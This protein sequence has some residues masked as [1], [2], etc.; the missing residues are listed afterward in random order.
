MMC[1]LCL[2]SLPRMEGE[3]VKTLY[4]TLAYGAIVAMLFCGRTAYA[5]KVPP[6]EKLLK[7]LEH[8]MLMAYVLLDHSAL[9]AIYADEYTNTSYDG[10]VFTKREV[11]DLVKNASLRL[12]S[13]PISDSKVKLLGNVAVITGVR[14]YWR[15]GKVLGVVRYTEVW[16]NRN[17]RW[18]CLSGQLTSVQE[19]K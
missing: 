8:Q 10:T 14:K 7:N 16:I 15:A 9:S 12:D 11:V 3:F 6:T 19:K 5:K 13:I 4:R 2:Q 17:N 1:R 18:Q